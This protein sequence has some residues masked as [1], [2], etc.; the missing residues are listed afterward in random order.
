MRYTHLQTPLGPLLAVAR[1]GWLV[2]LEFGHGGRPPPPAPDWIESP[3][4][5]VLAATR[6]QVDGYFA[7][8]R[9]DFDL[10]L[11]PA[12]TPFQL[13]AWEALRAIPYGHTISYAEQA[14]Q[15]GQPTATRAV[16]AANGRNPIVIVIP[17]H[18]VVGSDGALTGF[19]A[20]LAR[21]Q[22]L[23]RLE[24]ALPRPLL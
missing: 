13:R 1:D 8:R 18:R 24:G 5:P 7:G 23:L 19:A 9:R 14:A 3:A 17:C 4:D 16:G 6:Q 10:P 22:E 21:K 12:G 20:G 11:Q 2:S 15:L